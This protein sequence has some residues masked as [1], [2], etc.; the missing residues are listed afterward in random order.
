MEE[1]ETAAAD[2]TS[3]T[4]S[5]LHP[6]LPLTRSEPFEP[7]PK[8]RKTD[9]I[10]STP[11]LQ[12]FR[13]AGLQSLETRDGVHRYSRSGRII[14]VGIA[15]PIRMAETSFGS[16]DF[17][18][19]DLKG[20]PQKKSRSTPASVQDTARQQNLASSE[21]KSLENRHLSQAV[22]GDE[23][24]D[25]C[26]S[27]Q[28][29]SHKRRFDR[30]ENENSARLAR[31]ALPSKRRRS[32][33]HSS[34]S[35]SD[36]NSSSSSGSSS[37]SSEEFLPAPPIEGGGMESGPSRMESGPSGMELG[38]SGMELGPSGM[39]SRTAEEQQQFEASR[40]EPDV[41]EI[42]RKSSLANIG[43]PPCCNHSS[44]IACYT[45][46]YMC[47][48]FSC[49]HHTGQ[50]PPLLV[51]NSIHHTGQHSLL[52]VSNSIHHTGQHPPL[53]V[54]NSI[55]HTGQHSLLLVS[56]SIHHTGQHPPLLVSNSIHHTGQHSLLLVSNSIHHTGQHSLLLV[57]NNIHHTGQHPLLWVFNSIHQTG[58]HP[59]LLVFNSIHHTGQHPPL[60]VSNS[61]HHTGQ[62]SLLLVSNSIHHTGQHP[63]LLVSNS[64]HHTGQHPLPL[65]SNSIHHTG[66][67][68]P[69]KLTLLCLMYMYANTVEALLK[70]TWHLCIN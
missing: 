46:V 51:S 35:S 9:T 49:L 27:D 23:N 67:C 44:P 31:R 34:D 21:M 14:P 57:S 4:S 7:T 10:Q 47:I 8:G 50:H 58:Q 36:S 38:P 60:L 53:L 30:F 24:L 37:S 69:C 11:G 25:S 39:E 17:D 41:P 29:L 18:A 2:T 64:I 42:H 28:S 63:P 43:E 62:H 26:D 22:V 70:D 33:S 32:D 65:V 61:I 45:C 19:L 68:L 1:V 20:S 52:L 16:A 54:S 3:E 48:E 55:H 40:D 6:L 59:L 66:Q 12:G 5:P 56:N 13:E 15:Q